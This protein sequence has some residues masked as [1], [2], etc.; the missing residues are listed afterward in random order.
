MGFREYL[1]KKLVKDRRKLLP[2]PETL[3]DEA[4]EDSLMMRRLNAEGR[5]LQKEMEI[6]EIR[7]EHDELVHHIAEM[8][9][10]SGGGYGS[11]QTPEVAL[12]HLLEKIMERKTMQ[13]V[14]PTVNSSQTQN[15]PAG[16]VDLSIPQINEMLT[17]VPAPALKIAATLSDAAL[18]QEIL[19]Q[20]PQATANDLK[21]TRDAI[22]N[23]QL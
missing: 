9:A 21:N 20:Y 13:K 18:D 3:T 16:N 10:A 7:A 12:I 5:R 22:R 19:S 17:R 6:M 14:I 8:Q 15:T 4:R 1:A 23:R 11:G 2:D